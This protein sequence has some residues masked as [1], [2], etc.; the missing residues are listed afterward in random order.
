MY[1]FSSPQYIDI[2]TSEDNKNWFSKDVA[3][4]WDSPEKVAMA[5][6][7]ASK[8]LNFQNALGNEHP[9]W[10]PKSTSVLEYACGT[11]LI[12]QKLAPLTTRIVGLDVS[13]DMVDVFNQK[14][15]NQG[16]SSDEISAH[17]FDFLAEPPESFKPFNLIE[18]FDIVV[19]S[20]AYHHFHDI[21]IATKRLVQTLKPN[22][23]L[24]VADMIH[25]VHPGLHGS[26]THEA[27]HERG[28]AHMHGIAREM[29]IE[30]FKNNG[31]VDVQVGSPFAAKF[32]IEESKYVKGDEEPEVKMIG[33]KKMYASPIKIAV[34]A[35]RKGE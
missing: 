28:V 3:K 29:L 4:N 8:F 34:F 25:G 27:A 14:V 22:G 1:T 17:V 12:C 31:L 6:T 23:W 15:K 32:W 18:Q 9:R 2:M 16:L 13:P 33:E 26:W 11:G 35:G 10:D 24:F 19:V 5:E 21:D 7:I 30:N 20:M